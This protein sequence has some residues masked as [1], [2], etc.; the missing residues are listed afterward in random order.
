M[1]IISALLISLAICVVSAILEGIGAGKDV[2]GFFAKLRQ[3]SLA[4]PLWVWYI[5]GVVYYVMCFFLSYRILRHE[6]DD[7][8]KYAA[9]ALLLIY[10]GINAFWNFL[11][12]RFRNMLYAFLITLPYIPVAI[13]LFLC[14]WQFDRVAAFVFMP[15]LFYLVYATWLGYQNW[16]LNK[17]NDFK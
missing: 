5:I 9:L 10:M 14:L 6:G 3:P 13:G 11:F 15:Y 17:N 7:T 12:F 16:Q 2:K 8:L 1:S 4:P